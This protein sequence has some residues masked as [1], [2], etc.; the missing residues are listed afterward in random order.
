MTD[1]YGRFTFGLENTKT[2]KRTGRLSEIMTVS[3]A[4]KADKASGE[5]VQRI[6]FEESGKIGNLKK[7]WAFARESLKIGEAFRGLAILF[8]T[9]GSMVKDNGEKGSS[10][11]FSELFFAPIA[12]ELAPFK[13]IY[14]Y[15]DSDKYCGYFVC[16]M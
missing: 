3:L 11:D 2:K 6:Y 4:V 8:G 1:D 5:G 15:N 14:E 12:N 10:R 16:D 13:N 9:G 7:S